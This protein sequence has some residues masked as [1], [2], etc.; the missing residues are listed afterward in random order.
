MSNRRLPSDL[1][2]WS[3]RPCAWALARRLFHVRVV[4]GYFVLLAVGGLLGSGGTHGVAKTL[5]MGMVVAGLAGALAFLTAR[6]TRYE[7]FADRLVMRFG[8]ALPATLVLPLSKIGRVQIRVHADGTGDVTLGLVRGERL[9]YL[10]LWPHARPWRLLGPEP[11]LR[12]VPGAAVAG[13]LLSR[14][15]AARVAATALAGS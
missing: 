8:V 2:L 6:T 10:K 7:I 4:A 13:P 1:P 15:I 11:M 14:T 5:L 12:C 3:G 9:N